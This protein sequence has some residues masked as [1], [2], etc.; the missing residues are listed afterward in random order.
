MNRKTMHNILCEHA[1]L[2]MDA[3]NRVL[4]FLN[5]VHFDADVSGS[6]VPVAF[7]LRL[8]IALLLNAHLDNGMQFARFRLNALPNDHTNDSINNNMCVRVLSFLVE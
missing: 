1:H 6:R 2:S 5:N 4:M 7:F 3:S 8:S